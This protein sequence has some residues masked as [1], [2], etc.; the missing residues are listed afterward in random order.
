MSSFNI[1]LA[2]HGAKPR[3][4]S[5]LPYKVNFSSLS[6]GSGENITVSLS[7][8]GFLTSTELKGFIMQVE[9]VECL[10]SVLTIHQVSRHFPTLIRQL[11]ITTVF[12]ASNGDLMNF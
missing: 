1:D 3:D 5:E 2:G 6:A 11:V 10:A 8:S 4:V 9:L 7:G 12:I